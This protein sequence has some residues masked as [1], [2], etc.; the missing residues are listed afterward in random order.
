VVEK[1]GGFDQRFLPGEDVEF[2]FRLWRA[3]IRVHYV[4]EALLHYRYRASLLALWR[5]A[6]AYARIRP[7]LVRE[8]R[9]AGYEVPRD[10]EWRRWLWL[11][12]RLGS[13]RTKSGRARW[14]CVGGGRLGRLEGAARLLPGA[15]R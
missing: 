4:K 1:Y 2:S 5:Q 7:T 9:D 11:L 10:E 14:V 13:V 8:V 6:R 12:G 15:A 3:G